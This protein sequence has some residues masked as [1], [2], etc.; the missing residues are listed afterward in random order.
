M[1]KTLRDIPNRALVM[2]D[3][4]IVI[5]A[6]FPNGRYHQMCKELLQR[7]AQGEVHLRLTISAAADIV[8]RTMIL[9]CLAQ[10]H[11]QRAADAVTYLKQHPQTVQQLS[12]YKG[13]LSDLTQ[14]K[15][16]ILPLTYRDLHAS[17]QYREQYGLLTNDSLILAAMQRERIPYLATNDHDFDRIP[18]IA[19][20]WPE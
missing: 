11:V 3:T 8:H 19:V 17:K 2:V 15:V 12:R 5:Y 10:G 9:E 4:N 13:I 1:T 16:M 14:A 20:R 18:G 7:A 6:L